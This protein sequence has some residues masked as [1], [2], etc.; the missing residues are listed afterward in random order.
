MGC[1]KASV[2]RNWPYFFRVTDILGYRPV[3]LLGKSCYDFYI[4]EDV[5]YMAENYEQGTVFY[6]FECCLLYS[7]N[8]LFVNAVKRF[9]YENILENSGKYSIF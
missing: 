3:D 6:V 5:E 2:L 8:E 4:K 9:Y 1:V 7:V